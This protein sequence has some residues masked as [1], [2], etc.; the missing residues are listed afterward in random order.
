MI[1]VNKLKIKIKKIQI[2]LKTTNFQKIKLKYIVKKL[3]I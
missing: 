2:Y 3:K 1:N